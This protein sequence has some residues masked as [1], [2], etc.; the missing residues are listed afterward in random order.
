M[1]L[2]VCT[3]ENKAGDGRGSWECVVILAETFIIPRVP[4][5]GV[6]ISVVITI[7]VPLFKDTYIYQNRGITSI[8]SCQIAL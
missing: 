5:N 1:N 6:I 7:F 2:Q 8:K 3:G 4:I